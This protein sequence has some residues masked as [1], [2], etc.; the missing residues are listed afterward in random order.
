MAAGASTRG[1]LADAGQSQLPA[2]VRTAFL[3]EYGHGNTARLAGSWYSS[4]R[5]SA[6]LEAQW[7]HSGDQ[8]RQ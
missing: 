7:E 2:I 3:S 5:I 1:P 4:R 8:K 6:C